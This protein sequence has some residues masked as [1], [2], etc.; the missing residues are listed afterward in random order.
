MIKYVGVEGGGMISV[1]DCFGEVCV[2]ALVVNG[3][4]GF[5]NLTI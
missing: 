1:E 3:K 5:G 4:S 2:N